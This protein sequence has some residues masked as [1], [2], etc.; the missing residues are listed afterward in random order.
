MLS[1]LFA[2]ANAGAAF[3]NRTGNYHNLVLLNSL[4]QMPGVIQQ[5]QRACDSQ[6]ESKRYSEE[7]LN[8]YISFE[9]ACDWLSS[10]TPEAKTDVIYTGC[11]ESNKVL[12]RRPSERSALGFTGQRRPAL[13]SCAEGST[14]KGH[15]MTIN[16]NKNEIESVVWGKEGGAETRN[17]SEI[18][19]LMILCFLLTM[20]YCITHRNASHDRLRLVVSV[21]KSRCFKRA[22]CEIFYT[23][24]SLLSCCFI[25][26]K[27]SFFFN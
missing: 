21:P 23:E 25:D 2:D 8:M 10:L 4:C 17:Q 14:H 1:H 19:K 18:L 27:H 6:F 3:I 7:L 15:L 13:V 24:I 26:R 22:A 11:L 16:N 5:P 9:T 20:L 12:L